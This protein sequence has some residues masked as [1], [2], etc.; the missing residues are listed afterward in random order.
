[1]FWSN[2]VISY[3]QRLSNGGCVGFPAVVGRP[4][5]LYAT[6]YALYTG[7]YLGHASDLADEV[8]VFIQSCQSSE[9][10]LI[11]GPELNDFVHE[12]GSMHDLEHLTLHST[13]SVLPFCQDHG[14]ELRPIVAA[15]K[16]CDLAYLEL[17]LSERDLENAWF[18]GN[19]ILFVGQ[20]LL[21]LRDVEKIPEA[22]EALERWFKWLD[23]QMDPETSL[24]GTNG[25]CSNAAAVYGGYHQLLLYWHE[26]HPIV[27]P[28]GLVDT[29]LDLQ[30]LDGGFNPKGNGGA[31]EDVDSV[32]ILVNC[33][34]RYDYRRAD[35]RFALRRC[36]T[37]IL[38]TQ[39]PD[40]GFPYNRDQPQSHM[41]IP[42]TEAEPNVSCAFPTWFRVHTLALIAEILPDEP[43]F[44][45]VN[46]QF[47]KALSM[48]WH[49]SPI[50]WDRDATHPGFFASCCAR[51]KYWKSFVKHCMRQTFRRVRMVI[52]RCIKFVNRC[53][54]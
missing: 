22:S 41:G 36:K 18:E 17:W 42:G 20:L 40:G 35:I 38:K 8:V 37:H 46:F 47:N 33:Y 27:N 32:D 54:R 13:C 30:H 39:N 7:E 53:D 24:W 49:Q 6:V 1:M 9:T 31:C 28:A 44:E 23:E 12:A 51:F 26:E 3:L 21:Y 11:A 43:E 52:T 45:G 50:G 48:G 5:T 2:Q 25:S 34:K 19:N 16:F 29:V 14:I 4:E 15:H 10:G